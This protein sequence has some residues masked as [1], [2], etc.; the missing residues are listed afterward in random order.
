M[1]NT[2]LSNLLVFS[3]RAPKE[4]AGAFFFVGSCLLY[5]VVCGS[6]YLPGPGPKG[7]KVNIYC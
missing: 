6:P 2:T 4:Y 3:S 7:G 1:I 5:P